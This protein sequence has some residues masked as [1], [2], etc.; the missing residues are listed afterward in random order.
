MDLEL[1]EKQSE[2]LADLCF[3]LT[4]GLLLGSF[5]LILIRQVELAVL[6]VIMA[7]GIS[8]ALVKFGLYLLR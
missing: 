4:N 6:Y 3:N 7:S 1:N 2:K 8:I 5:G